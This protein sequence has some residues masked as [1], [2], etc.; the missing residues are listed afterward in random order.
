MQICEFNHK[1]Y[2]FSPVFTD[3]GM[4]TIK[5]KDHLCLKEIEYENVM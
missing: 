4:R 5:I 3:N 1:Q 2:K